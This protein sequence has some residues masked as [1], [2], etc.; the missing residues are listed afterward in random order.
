VQS[1]IT[2]AVVDD[3]IDT[4]HCEF[5]GRVSGQLDAAT[6]EP[7]SLPRG[8][9]PHGTKVAG[10]A[11]A[12]GVQVTGVAPTAR[13][14]AVRVPALSSRLGDPTEAVAI[15]WAAQ[16]GADVI[17]CAWGPQELD[18]RTASLPR[19]TR[20]AID[21][22]LWHG[23]GGKGCVV[24]FSSGNHGS[25]IARNEYASHPG[26]IAVGACNCHG[27]HPEYS[28]W[29]GALW[30][31]V[32]SN[33][34]GDPVGALGTYATTTP[35]GSFLL[36]DTF[37]TDEFGF[38]SAAC[39]VAAGVCAQILS[40]NSGLT[41]L[42]VREIVADSCRKIDVEGGSYDA[43]GHSP[44]YGYGRL[45]AEGAIELAHRKFATSSVQ[46]IRAL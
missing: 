24:L 40:A 34:P 15:R 42:E 5:A 38:T 17:C 39:A 23:R 19:S 2:I 20:D 12:G 35:V 46:S 41:S 10:L 1:P 32:Q 30:C 26:V 22:A 29:G 36:G 27:K 37:Y 25:D 7:S 6:G 33:D 14:L 11:L 8:W 3:A 9:Q 44:L 45:D 16:H 31:V 4:R 13:L 21:F 28:G 43:K 18:G